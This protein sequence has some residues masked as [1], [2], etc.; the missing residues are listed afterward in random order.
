MGEQRGPRSDGTQAGMQ[1]GTWDSRAVKEEKRRLARELRDDRRERSRR[2]SEAPAERAQTHARRLAR[3]DPDD[4]NMMDAAD[5]NY[6]HEQVELLAARR[7]HMR[8]ERVMPSP[9]P[10]RMLA[11]R[12]ARRA[13]RRAFRR[14]RRASRASR[15][16]PS[17][18]D[19]SWP[20]AGI[21]PVAGSAHVVGD[22]V[23]LDAQEPSRRPLSDLLDAL[24]D[25]IAERVAERLRESAPLPSDEASSRATKTLASHA[26]VG[27]AARLTGM[28]EDRIRRLVGRHE[29]AYVRPGHRSLLVELASLRAWLKQRTVMPDDG[30]VPLRWR[31]TRGAP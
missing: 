27:E 31:R 24:I 8:R 17:S 19:P 9:L 23:R 30:V 16:D 3:C 14:P 28:T 25:G 2:A 20:A 29:V 1:F 7:Q 21:S 13:P 6:E 4:P 10:R 15:G 12:P 18:P 5:E 22:R 26:T 11:R